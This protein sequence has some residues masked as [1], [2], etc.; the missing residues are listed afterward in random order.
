MP[1][2]DVKLEPSV[3]DGVVSICSSQYEPS[4]ADVDAQVESNDP[5]SRARG[6]S[7]PDNLG[8]KGADNFEGGA[9]IPGPDVV[10]ANEEDS[11]SSSRWERCFVIGSLRCC[12]GHLQE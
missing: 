4:V 5:D 8:S 1:P 7:G 12:G 10:P 9:G 2:S 11:D 6:E 3:C